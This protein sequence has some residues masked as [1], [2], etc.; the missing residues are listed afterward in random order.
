ML[1]DINIDEF[2][3]S[4]NYLQYKASR[5]YSLSHD[6]NRKKKTFNDY[7]DNL[8]NMHYRDGAMK[9]AFIFVSIYYLILIVPFIDYVMFVQFLLCFSFVRL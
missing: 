5:S 8:E 6:L 7:N 2:Y 9:I 4:N 1:E 3:Q